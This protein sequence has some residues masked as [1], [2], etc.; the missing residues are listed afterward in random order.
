MQLCFG[1]VGCRT[2]KALLVST[3]TLLAMTPT[4]LFA[5][6][7]NHELIRS[8]GGYLSALKIGLVVVVFLLWVR[9]ADWINR[10]SMKLGDDTGLRPEVWN[11]IN[12]VTFLIGFFTAISVPTFVAGYPIFLVIA[13]APPAIYW[14]VRRSKI[15]ASPAIAVKATA[16]PGDVPT[17]PPLPQDEGAIMDFI[18]AGESEKDRQD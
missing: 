11:P 14:L 13:L 1:H 18:P 15:K 8:G 6:S 17:A 16:K 7:V 12:V 9:L 10:D 3:T 2:R 4:E 5:Q